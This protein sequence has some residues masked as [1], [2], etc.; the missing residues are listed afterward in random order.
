M[1]ALVAVFTTPS[2]STAARRLSGGHPA[3]RLQ[4]HTKLPPCEGGTPSRQPARWQLCEKRSILS[5]SLLGD[6]SDTR[7]STGPGPGGCTPVW[8]RYRRGLEWSAQSASRRRSPPCGWR[9]CDAACA[10]WP[11]GQF[12]Q[13]RPEPSA[14]PAVGS[15]CGHLGPGTRVET[16]S[17]L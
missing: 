8:S 6:A 14:R 4:C 2:C 9:S 1:V 11:S 3:L 17:L 15:A 7:S 13:P 5:P 16:L 12:P 10:D